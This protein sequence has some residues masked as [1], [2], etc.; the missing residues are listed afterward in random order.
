MP[1]KRADLGNGPPGLILPYWHSVF[2]YVSL[3]NNQQKENS[4][5]RSQGIRDLHGFYEI[6]RRKWMEQEKELSSLGSDTDK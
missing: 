2:L 4:H 5:G 6:M 1:Q 3:K